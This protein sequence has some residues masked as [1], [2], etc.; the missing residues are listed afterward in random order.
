[1]QDNKSL[2]VIEL[3]EIIDDARQAVDDSC[4]GPL[5]VKTTNPDNI[6]ESKNVISQVSFQLYLIIFQS[7]VVEYAKKDNSGKLR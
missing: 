2:R 7:L 3:T 6:A 4:F 5:M 1:M